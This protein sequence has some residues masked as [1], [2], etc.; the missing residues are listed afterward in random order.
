MVLI[1]SFPIPADHKRDLCITKTLRQAM[2]S[3][4]LPKQ[5]QGAVIG[6]GILVHKEAAMNPG[7]TEMNGLV[8]STMGLTGQVRLNSNKGANNRS[9]SGGQGCESWPCTRGRTHGQVHQHQQQTAFQGASL[10]GSSDGPAFTVCATYKLP[11]HCKQI[12]T[13]E[14]CYLPSTNNCLPSYLLSSESFQTEVG[15]Q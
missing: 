7:L 14:T 13:N 5:T 6:T 15:K 12:K 8:V 2:L 9:R 1:H 4:L 3:C 10:P 11:H